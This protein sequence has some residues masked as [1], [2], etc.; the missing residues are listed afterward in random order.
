MY[1]NRKT[2]TERS[3]RRPKNEEI[4]TNY[5]IIV[6]IRGNGHV[7]IVSSGNT[8]SWRVISQHFG[9]ILFHDFTY[10]RSHDFVD[11]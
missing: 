10:N 6:A 11:R 1:P 8:R 3:R 9:Y 2:E 7:A 4:A 5:R